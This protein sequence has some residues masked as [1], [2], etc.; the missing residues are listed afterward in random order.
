M[1]NRQP[2]KAKQSKLPKAHKASVRHAIRMF[3]ADGGRVFFFPEVRMTVAVIHA[4]PGSRMAVVGVAIASPTETKF[5]KLMGA[6]I[7]MLRCDDQ[8]FQMPV[9]PHEYEDFAKRLACTI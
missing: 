1:F 9:Q 8:G 7:A 3:E 5:R 4:F 2:V 6:H